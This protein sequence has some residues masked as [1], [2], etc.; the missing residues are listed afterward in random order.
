MVELTRG[1]DTE[2]C[3]V[4]TTIRDASD[5]S[6]SVRSITDTTTYVGADSSYVVYIYGIA[7]SPGYTTFVMSIAIPVCGVT[8][9]LAMTHLP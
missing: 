7:P 6:P 9:T 8:V 5:V 2:A 3:L 4:V 1:V